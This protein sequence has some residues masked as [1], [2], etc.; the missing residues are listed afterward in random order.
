VLQRFTPQQLNNRLGLAPCE[1]I[2]RN[3][4]WV[5]R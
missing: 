3:T 2:R 5:M 4:T 1:N